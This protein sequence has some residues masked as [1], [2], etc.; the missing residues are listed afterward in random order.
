MPPRKTK[1]PGREIIWIV[2]S[3]LVVVNIREIEGWLTRFDGHKKAPR[4]EYEKTAVPGQHAQRDLALFDDAKGL[5][6]ESDRSRSRGIRLE[7]DS[8]LLETLREQAR[9]EKSGAKRLEGLLAAVWD[10]LRDLENICDS[11]RFLEKALSNVAYSVKDL[12]TFVNEKSSAFRE[13]REFEEIFGFFTSALINHLAEPSEVELSPEHALDYVGYKNGMKAPHKIIVNGDLRYNTACQMSGGSLVL[14]G[15]AKVVANELQGGEVEIHGNVKSLSE[16]MQGG[17]VVLRGNAEIVAF[18]L[19]GGR[20]DVWGDVYSDVASHMLNGEVIIH[21][22]A[23]SVAYMLRDG[24]VVVKKDVHEDTGTKM[25]N[26]IVRVFGNSGLGFKK[27]YAGT[28]QEGG[29]IDIY[30]CVEG[31]GARARGGEIHV[32]GCV[33]EI[34]DACKSKVYYRDK[35]LNPERD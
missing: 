8:R 32:H 31:V 2:L 9:S 7:E 4:E 11:E 16:E 1:L 25:K 33:P 6:F 34:L 15:S 20:V 18:K 19:K 3:V 28:L 17:N 13:K 24:L 29:R 5:P 23:R 30:G 10:R 14:H 27:T 22:S 26:G 21:G 12:E 35:A